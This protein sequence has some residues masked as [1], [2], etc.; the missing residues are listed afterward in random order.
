MAKFHENAITIYGLAQSAE[1]NSVVKSAAETVGTITTSTSSTGVTGVSTT[2]TTDLTVGGYIYKADGSGIIGRVESITNDT[3]AVLED[4]A[5]FA[6]TA[7]EYATG[8]GPKNCL[9]VLDLTYQTERTTDA[10]QYTGNELDRDERTTETDKYCKID[11]SIFMP[12]LGVLAGADPASTE[13]PHADFFKSVRFAVVPSIDGSGTVTFTNDTVVVKYLTVEYRQS[14]PEN[15]GYQKVYVSKDVR[16]T[17]DLDE[18]ISKRGQLKFSL[19]G[20][21]QGLED[22]I[23]LTPDET[24]YPKQKLEIGPVFNKHSIS[25][26][27]LSQYTGDFEET[28]P[29]YSAGTKNVCIDKL[30]APN[31]S[32]FEFDRILTS[33]LESWSVGAVPT[34]L[35]LTIL[36]QEA[37]VTF[38]PDEHIEDHFSLFVD[39]STDGT[40]LGR[41]RL[42]FTK[43]QLVDVQKTKIGKYFGQD[44]K[45]RNIGKTSIV[46]LAS[47]A[48]T[49]EVSL[50]PKY[51][52]GPAILSANTAGLSNLLGAMTDIPSSSNNGAAGTFTNTTTSGNYGYIAITEAAY[53]GVGLHIYDG[54]GYGGWSGAGLSGNNTGASPDPTV[55]SVSVEYNGVTWRIFRQ[56]YVNA[57]PSGGSYTISSA[58]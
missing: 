8:L 45:F 57:D 46:L 25:T 5:A 16:G 53:A 6:V 50:K 47:A 23:E 31:L 43:L 10:F 42:V 18:T 1:G 39:Y 49:P 34:D 24:I 37:E 48:G 15:D 55:T 12:Q 26:L 27:Q 20:N 54:T 19:M 9:A 41:I 3:A 22:K 4:N 40:E 44:V 38:N 32:G 30:Q 29:T 58:A 35:T 13:I 52:I 36:E 2:F 14:S 21:F 28:V 7:A 17:L 33:C 51:G 56:D 11:F